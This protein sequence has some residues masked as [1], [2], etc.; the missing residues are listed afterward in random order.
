MEYFQRQLVK[1]NYQIW[2]FHLNKCCFYNLTDVSSWFILNMCL[3][4]TYSL[5]TLKENKIQLINISN[6]T[7]IQ[8]CQEQTKWKRYFEKNVTNVY[9][10]TPWIFADSYK[11]RFKNSSIILYISALWKI[12]GSSQ[13]GQLW[14][15]SL[16]FLQQVKCLQ[17]KHMYSHCL[18]RQTLQ[19]FK[20]AISAG[21][22]K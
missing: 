7:L 3:K 2:V 6:L 11:L 16:H 21:S 13:I 18:C 20:K 1:I 19:V 14:K 9:F 8:K 5:L 4:I 17:G 15:T 22:E 10:P 12:I